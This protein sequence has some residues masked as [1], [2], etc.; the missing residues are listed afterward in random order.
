MSELSR[1]TTAT[2]DRRRGPVRLTSTREVERMRELRAQ[3]HGNVDVAR[4][5]GIHPETVRR[6]IG[7]SRGERTRR[8]Q[9]RAQERRLREAP[10]AEL[11]DA[12]LET[13]HRLGYLTKA[14]Y[15]AELG[16]R[17]RA[18]RV[19]GLRRSA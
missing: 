11:S 8:R 10:P 12:E 1:T 15:L 18:D 7:P 17:E 5:M 16:I 2:S 6:Y 19:A 9:E 3:G 14:L 4:L 13:A